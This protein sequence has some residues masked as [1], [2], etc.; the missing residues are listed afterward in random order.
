[1]ITS[2]CKIINVDIS[3]YYHW[4]KN[5]AIV[6][7]VDEQL[8]ELIEIAFIQGRQNYGTRRIKDKLAQLYGLVLSRRKIGIIMKEQLDILHKLKPFITSIV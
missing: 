5:G 4:I 3:S 6:H 7:K 1:M 8:N 2:M